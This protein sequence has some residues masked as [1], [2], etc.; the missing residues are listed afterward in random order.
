[1]LQMLLKSMAAEVLLEEY[2]GFGAGRSMVEQIFNCR[3]II[4][5][6][7]EHQRNL[8]HNFIYFK[9]AFDRVCFTIDESF[10]EIVLQ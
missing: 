6:H 7:L 2:A 5:K 4:E 8:Y 10:V 1:M 3:I 9:N